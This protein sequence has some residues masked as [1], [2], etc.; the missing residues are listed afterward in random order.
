MNRKICI[1]IVVIST[2]ISLFFLLSPLEKRQKINERIQ[3]QNTI[4]SNPVSEPNNVLDEKSEEKEN[5]TASEEGGAKA[6]SQYPQSTDTENNQQQKD[7]GYD[8]EDIYS[9][10]DTFT[11]A[12]IFKVDKNTIAQNMPLLSKAKLF[13]YAG[14]LKGYDYL[15]IRNILSSENET[16]GAKEIFRI[17]KRDFDENQ[18]NEIKSILNPYINVDK[19]EQY[20]NT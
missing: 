3:V 15:R 4:P 13:Y 12:M 8:I 6:E 11:A 5:K 19:I 17:L 2:L 14:E 9:K 16:E 7:S 18:Y 10:E 1:I 20:L